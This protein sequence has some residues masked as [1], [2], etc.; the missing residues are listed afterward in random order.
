MLFRYSDLSEKSAV[1]SLTVKNALP[2]SAI[3]RNVYIHP[4]TRRMHVPPYTHAGRVQDPNNTGTVSLRYC[5]TLASVV[6]NSN[7]K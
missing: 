3:G 4:C 2:P 1:I 7:T 5:L 6:K